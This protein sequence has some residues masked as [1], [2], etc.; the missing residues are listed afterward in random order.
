MNTE[1]PGTAVAEPEEKSPP[2]APSSAPPS[3]PPGAPV[4]TSAPADGML[5]FKK[6]FF[7][8]TYYVN[9][10]PVQFEPLDRNFGVLKISASDPVASALIASARANGGKGRGGIVAITEQEAEELKKKLPFKSPAVKSSPPSLR[11]VPTQPPKSQK[12]PPRGDGGVVV[13]NP[14]P[15][16]RQISGGDGVAV[17]GGGTIVSPGKAA[18]APAPFQEPATPPG[19]FRPATGKKYMKM[20][21]LRKAS[22]RSLVSLNPTEE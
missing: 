9:G 1:E 15:R 16:A 7:S 18:I 10:K 13:A 4:T 11:V 5:Y 6:V 20:P 14:F 21:V 22:G 8:T 17:G 3:P 12:Q 19:E 2:T